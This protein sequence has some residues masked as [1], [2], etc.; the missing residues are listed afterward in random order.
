MHIRSIVAIARKDALDILL[1]RTTFFS[2]LSPIFLAVLFTIFTNVLGTHYINILVYNPGN[3]QV[4]QVV[5]GVFSH[6]KITLAGSAQQVSDAFGPDG[7]HKQSDYDLG[8]VIPPDFETAVH[9]GK[10]PQVN[11]YFNGD[12]I[13]ATDR[14]TIITLVTSYASAVANPQ[15]LTVMAATINPPKASPI[16][17]LK[18]MYIAIS[19]LTS[20]LVGTSLVPSLL[21]EEKEKK[22]L[23]MLMVTPASF[24]DMVLGK[25]LVG[26][27]Y[28][29]VLTVLVLA[30]MQGLT[31]NI[32]LLFLFIVLGST[33][34]LSLGLVVGSIF[35]T[36]SAV[37]AFIGIASLFFVYSGLFIGP[38]QT[39]MGGN[40]VAQA[41]KALPTYYIADGTFRA[42]Q[43]NGLTSEVMLDLS[44]IVVVTIILIVASSALLRQQATKAAT[45]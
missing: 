2:L 4:T 13:T 22:T 38:L 14:Q 15:P 34:S 40:I 37:G 9:Q 23:R 41:A 44:V 3:S 27:A 18:G 25:L 29:L 7:A 45:I 43:N 26:L 16:V 39:L 10:K 32:P 24:T 20:F 11:M 1:N 35:Q 12:N 6:T 8:M 5:T 28:Q 21:I 30:L 33:F 31:G 19:L 36:S 17:D 42:I